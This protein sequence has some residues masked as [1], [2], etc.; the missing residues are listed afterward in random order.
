MGGEAHGP[1]RLAILGTRGVPARYG[2]FE[3]FAEQIASRLARRGHHVTVYRRSRYA[4]GDLP[5][6]EIVTLP[7]VYTKHL[8]TVSHGLLSVLHCASRRP[9]A[10]LVCNAANA[11][12]LPLLAAAGVATALN[13]DG[14][15]WQRRKWSAVG[16][17]GHR[18]GEHLGVALA[19][20]VITDARVIQSYY[21]RRH[22]VETVFIPYGGDLEP[23][24]SSTLLR[25][26]D[27]APGAYDLCVCRFEPENNPLQV[28]RAHALLDAPPPLVMVGGAPYA[29]RYVEEVRQAAGPSVRFAGFRFGEE[30]RQLLFHARLVVYAGEV[31]G[32]HPV[33][34][35][36]MGAG[37]PVLYNDTPENREAVGRAGVPFPSGGGA[38]G[39]AA[40]W[41]RLS[42]SPSMQVACA[43]RGR[44]RVEARYRWSA[45][46][47]AYEGLLRGL[48]ARRQVR[49]PASP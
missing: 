41:G 6:V 1:L 48:A 16:R 28:V 25:E 2:G 8:E 18:L 46:T 10:A 32:T 13:V 24:S 45:V 23:P 15:E 44:A 7:A 19:D 34:L 37:R 31:G 43:R 35:E 42:G 11:P 22:G 27:L 14:I 9:D 39:L 29:R 40:A 30:Y 49:A 4:Q 20:A 33:L 5:G 12:L 3:T 47:D 36:A 21:R 38:A 26:L 17:G